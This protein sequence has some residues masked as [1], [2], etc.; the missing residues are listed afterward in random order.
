MTVIPY[1]S[2][3]DAANDALRRLP[4]VLFTIMVHLPGGEEVERVYSTHPEVYPVSGRKKL[5]PKFTS[6]IWHE[7][8]VVKQRGYV[9]S[10][11]AAVRA[12]FYD[13]A[14]IESLGCDSI[15][16]TPI[17][18]NGET[19]GTINFLGAEHALTDNLLPLAMEITNAATLATE[20]AR[21]NLQQ[22]DHKNTINA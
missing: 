13:W 16:N 7:Q 2:L 10:D 12:F 17:V 19:I 8:V 4:V 9:G 5:D 20:R 21:S 14:T 3:E 6:P 22:L 1:H 11:Q 15:I 18:L